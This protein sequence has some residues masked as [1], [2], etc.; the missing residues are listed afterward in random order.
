ME[1]FS[2]E[3]DVVL[4]LLYEKL[5]SLLFCF[6][7]QCLYL[8]NF[9]EQIWVKFSFFAYNSDQN[10]KKAIYHVNLK[11]VEKMTPKNS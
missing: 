5:P 2:F 6:G 10:N 7:F 3:A 1:G 8:H 9:V 4:E 11:T